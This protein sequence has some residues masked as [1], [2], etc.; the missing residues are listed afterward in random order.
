MSDWYCPKC[1]EDLPGC[2]VNYDETCDTCGCPVYIP[3]SPWIS[4]EDAPKKDG[5]YWCHV[6]NPEYRLT[7]TNNCDYFRW[8]E[9]EWYWPELSVPADGITHWMPL[10]QLPEE[11]YVYPD[12]LWGETEEDGE[13]T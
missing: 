7:E 11:T 4:V 13:G 10:P 5:V 3:K 12:S 8:H 2:R 9:G 1:D 6:V